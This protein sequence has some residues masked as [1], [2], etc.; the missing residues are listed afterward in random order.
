MRG[1][2]LFGSILLAGMLTGPVHA[3]VY[4]WT[5]ER[6]V[7]SF[8]DDPDKV[9]A[10]YRKNMKK[11]EIETQGTVRPPAPAEQTPVSPAQP[12]PAEQTLYNGH[13]I[14]WWSAQFK[15]LRDEQKRI[16]DALP[17]KRV[18][19]TD[20]HR[21]RVFY[22]RSRDRVAYNALNDEIQQD[23]ARLKELQGSLDRLEAEADRF[24]VPR[25]GR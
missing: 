17:E 12:A 8:T 13:D 2:S 3:T 16:S 6:G 20:L 24:G 10:R 1:Y 23:E 5:D 22:Q 19:L 4:E 25:E 14:G 7:V 21:Q 9:P 11:Q 18:R 15:A